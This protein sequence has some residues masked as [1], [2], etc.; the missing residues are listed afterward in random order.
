MTSRE[1]NEREKQLYADTLRRAIAELRAE[2]DRTPGEE[3]RPF[4]LRTEANDLEE[5]LN[6]L[7]G[8]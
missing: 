5:Q 8:K 7:L 6:K 2:A 1:V 3:L 4:M